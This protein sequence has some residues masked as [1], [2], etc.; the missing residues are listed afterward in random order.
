M[1]S[2]SLGVDMKLYVIVELIIFTE[3]YLCAFISTEQA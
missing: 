2:K 1:V 3:N